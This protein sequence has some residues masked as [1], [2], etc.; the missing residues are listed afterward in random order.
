MTVP[1]RFSLPSR[2]RGRDQANGSA[3][4]SRSARV[5][6]FELGKNVGRP[7]RGSFFICSIGVSPTVGD[8][9]AGRAARGCGYGRHAIRVKEREG[10]ASMPGFRGAKHC[11]VERSG[12]SCSAAAK[13]RSLAALGMTIVRVSRGARSCARDNNH[14]KTL[15]RPRKLARSSVVPLSC[16]RSACRSRGRGLPP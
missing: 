6:V 15:L 4:F 13:C 10:A 11:H 16:G 7:G 12:G 9:V 8:V 3:V 2:S 14:K 1:P 5:Q